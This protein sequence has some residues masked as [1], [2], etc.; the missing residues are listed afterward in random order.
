VAQPGALVA[1]RAGDADQVAGGALH[2]AGGREN[3]RQIGINRIGGGQVEAHPGMAPVQAEDAMQAEAAAV[4]TLVAAPD[5]RQAS[6]DLPRRRG[7]VL[8]RLAVRGATAPDR[9]TD[10]RLWG[11][12]DGGIVAEE[13]G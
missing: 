4:P 2:A 8:Q 5:R 1:A 6:A 13:H 7:K 9:R 12:V 11:E 3:A 10:A